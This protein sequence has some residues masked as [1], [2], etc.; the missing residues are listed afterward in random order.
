MKQKNDSLDK[1][2]F[3]CESPVYRIAKGLRK[4]GYEIAGHMGVKQKKPTCNMVGILKEREPIQKNFYGIKYNQNQR[5]LYVATLWI[6]SE[7]KKAIEDKRWVLEVND[8]KY[9]TKLTKLVEKLSLPYNVKIQ[10]KLLND[11]R[12]ETYLSEVG[13]Y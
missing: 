6:N 10:V 4:K 9:K 2:L 13:F 5:A 12:E 11:P 3:S 7:E 1:I 8:E